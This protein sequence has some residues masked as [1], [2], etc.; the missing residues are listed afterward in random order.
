MA[1]AFLTAERISRTALALLRRDIVLPRLVW[2]QADADFRGAKDDTVTLRVP[3]VLT[4][5]DYGMRNDRTNPIVIDDLAELSVDVKLTS[6]PYS[7]VAI[8]DEQLTLDIADFAGQVLDPQTRAVAE[9]LEDT[10]AAA[11]DAADV[12]ADSEIELD[13]DNPVHTALDA[14]RI[15]NINNVPMSERVLLL[16]ANVEMTFLDDDRLIRVD[17]SGSDSALRDATIG[18]VAGFTVV[19][20]NAIDPD[21][22]YAFHRT[23]VAFANMAPVVPD[24]ATMGESRNIAGLA[25]RWIRDYDPTHLQDRSVVSAFAGAASVDDG[26]PD[27]PVNMRLVKI[28]TGS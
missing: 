22:G 26:D 28:S 10:I 27:T 21:V 3:A 19:T 15:L 7:A 2:A 11:L 23:A 17:A 24:G 5:R 9:K 6:Q 18:R 12:P 20:S 4:A 16:G 1:N 13:E 14:R 25:M 8:T